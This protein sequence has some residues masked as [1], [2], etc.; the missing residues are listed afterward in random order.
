MSATIFK[1]AIVRGKTLAQVVRWETEPFL[2]VPISGMTVAA[3]AG[4]STTVPHGLTD[5][6]RVAVVGAK[7]MTLLN[8]ANNPPKNKDLRR[9]TV[10]DDDHIEFNE[11]NTVDASR[12]TSGGFLQFYTPQSLVGYIARLT[13]KNRVGG[14]VLLALTSVAGDIVLDDTAKTI[15]INLSAT[16]TAALT[17][18]TGV[19]DLELESDDGVVTAVL[20][21]TVAVSNEITT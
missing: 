12:W 19:Y 20:E 16:V 15:T 13:I 5:G 17:W 3:P 14:D 2:F 8:A 9:C 10:V 6:W 7:G 4:V 18:K 11:F 21:G 1:L